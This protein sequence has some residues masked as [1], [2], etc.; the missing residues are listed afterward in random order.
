MKY[1]LH[2]KTD[3]D[4]RLALR[5]SFFSPRVVEMAQDREDRELDRLTTN[6]APRESAAFRILSRVL[7]EKFRIPE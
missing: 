6:L 7:Y 3:S 2:Q 5:S 4:Q 1:D